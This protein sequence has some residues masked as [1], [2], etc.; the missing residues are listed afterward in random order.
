MPIMHESDTAHLYMIICEVDALHRLVLFQRICNFYG[1]IVACIRAT[2]LENI[3][4]I[5]MEA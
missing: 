4:R 5:Q 2:Q 1:L 3:E